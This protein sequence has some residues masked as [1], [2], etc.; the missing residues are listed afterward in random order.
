MTKGKIAA[1]FQFVIRHS[2]MAFLASSSKILRLRAG[3]ETI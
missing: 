2:S 3:C 1:E